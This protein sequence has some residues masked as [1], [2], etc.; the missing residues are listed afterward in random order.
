[1]IRKA[2]RAKFFLAAGVG[3]FAQEVDGSGLGHV[4]QFDQALVRLQIGIHVLFWQYARCC[5]L[6]SCHSGKP[7]TDDHNALLSRCRFRNDRFFGGEA[8]GQNGA[9]R[10][11]DNP[12]KRTA[13]DY[14]TT[15][16]RIRAIEPCCAARDA[17]AAFRAR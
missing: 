9:H 11:A 16:F 5:A 1:M 14:P 10:N 8:I 13:R 17:V 3:E 7:S 6:Q 12:W 4:A 15:V 2:T